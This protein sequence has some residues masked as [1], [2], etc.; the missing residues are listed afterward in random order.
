LTLPTICCPVG[1][2]RN[3]TAALTVE[4]F[5]N[6]LNVN[7]SY[8]ATFVAGGGSPGRGATMISTRL[9]TSY[10]TR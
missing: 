8:R 4:N 3:A 7:L 6:R 10:T 2:R 9:P 1:L 5:L